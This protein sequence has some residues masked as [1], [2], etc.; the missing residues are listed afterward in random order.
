MTGKLTKLVI[1]AY[2]DKTYKSRV[3]SYTLQINPD[4][5]KRSHSTSYS[6][7]QTQE[8]AAQTTKFSA[9]APQTVSFEFYLDYSGVLEPPAGL[10]DLV[11]AIRK[12]KLCAY[13]YN[14]TIHSPNYLRLCWTD[15]QFKC[16][17]TSLDIEYTLFKPNG[18]PLRAKLSV[19]FEEYIREEEGTQ[20]GRP[21][22]PDLS[23]IR[24][25]RA[26]DTLPLLC[27]EI[28]GASRHYIEVARYNGLSQFRQLA[29]GSVLHFP[30]LGDG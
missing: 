18:T 22:S 9:I 2:S 4:S 6:K 25:V 17:L 12:F 15:L 27:Y 19:S 16:R 7:D 3:S 14:G 28:Y 20:Q 26:G 8:K 23:H 30:P 13:N 1:E 10:P 29:V 5:Y 21:E 24:T 11:Q